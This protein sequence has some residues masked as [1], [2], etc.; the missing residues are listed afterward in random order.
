MTKPCARQD[1][2]FEVTIAYCVPA[3]ALMAVTYMEELEDHGQRFN[4]RVRAHLLTL[5]LKRRLLFPSAC[6]VR[7]TIKLHEAARVTRE[8]RQTGA[9]GEPCGTSSPSL[10][11]LQLRLCR[12]SSASVEEES[13]PLS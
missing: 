13:T 7:T 9:L 4:A 10:S 2:W 8:G 1:L 5:K 12:S 3:A 6:E 11:G